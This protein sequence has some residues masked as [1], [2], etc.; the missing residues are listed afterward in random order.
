MPRL[1]LKCPYLKGGSEST[2]AHLE[3]LVN[4]IA[5]R[6]RVEKINIENKNLVS[7]TK[8]EELIVQIVKEFPE[9]KS[10]FEYE[11][12]IKNPTIENASEFIS[13][14][15]EQNIDKL[16]KRKN[17]VDYIAN[18]P[19]VEKM[20]KHGLFTGGDDSLVLSKI[21]DEVANHEGNVWTPIISLRREDATRLGFDNAESWHNMLSYYA[22]DIAESLKIKPENFQWYAAFHN[23]GHHPHVHMICYSINPKEGYLTK[24]GIEKMKSGFVKNIFGEELKEVYMEQ[25][26]RRDKLKLE[27]REV[28]LQLISEMKNDTF[29]NGK[30]EEQFMEFAERLKFTK[31]KKQYGYLQ[32]KLKAMVDGI[33][34]EL[35]KDERIS[36]AYELWYEM[37]NEVLYSYVDNLPEPLPLSQQKEFKSIK[38]MIIKEADNF[39]KGMITFEEITGD[40]IDIIDERIDKAIDDVVKNDTE[41]IEMEGDTLDLIRE[42][43]INDDITED[44][45][46]KWSDDY[47][48]ACEFLF[49]TDD[50]VQDF[51]EA[52]YLFQS[53]VEQ[54]NALAMFNMGRMFADGLGIEIDIEESY[55]WYEKALNAFHRIEDRKPWKYTEYRIGKM[56]SQGLG[57][58]E[59]YEKAAYWLTLS[60]E[61]RYKFAEYSLG[62]L[63]YRGQGVEQSYERAFEFYLKSAKQSFPYAKFEVAKMYRDGIG[64]DINEEESD[65]YFSYA[66]IGFKRLEKK[67]HDDKIQYRLGWMLQNGIGTEKDI[68]V[69][70][71]YYEKSAKLGNT[72]A[73]YSLAKLILAEE[74]P[75]E[76]EVKKAIEYL[77][78]A[79]TS[80]NQFAQYSLGKLYLDGEYVDKD[81]LKA[82]ELFK[83]SSEQGNEYASYQLGKLYLKGEDITKDIPSAIKWLYLSAEKGNQYAQYLLG[84]IYLMGEGLPRDK[85]EAIKWFKLSAEQGNE[86]AQ[87]FLDNMDKFYNPSVSL[88]VSKM[89]HHMSKTF[90]D[91]I[92]LKSSGVGI[93]VDS[94]LLRKLR[95]KKMAQGHKEDDHEQQNIKL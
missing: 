95:E 60:A 46:V 14:A 4:Y 41:F 35:A 20:G 21:A 79:S 1:I 6:D 15:L 19:R 9:T 40:D 29:Q 28:L 7:T 52:F 23:E 66:F 25:S 10:L 17:Y 32:P 56:Y 42:S 94:K 49:G 62:G 76:G 64:T 91:N 75:V 43:E 33:V 87:F 54:G 58:E 5:T 90:E 31:G 82:V 63:Y 67:S 11:D 48:R 86:Y 65:K 92:P 70:K 89:F 39:N 22:I 83:L 16:G 50:I 44:V 84:K 36:K 59:D 47:K 34:D 45:Y 57:T 53:E 37:R 18:R 12:Y 68:G 51:E 73:C 85:E 27:S 13:I 2:S 72:F 81:T 71:Q 8:Q 38:N 30:I 78:Q 55:E 80:G 69:A 88:A 93:K 3:N 77:K 26:K 24:K 61:E 74:N